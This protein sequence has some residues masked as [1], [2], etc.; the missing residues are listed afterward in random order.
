VRARLLLV[1]GVGEHC[2][3]YGR[4]VQG[5]TV[6]G[7]EVI[8]WDQRGHGLSTG[9]RGH[10]QAWSDYTSD[11]TQVAEWVRG[12]EECQ[13]PCFLYGHSMGG[14]VALAAVLAEAQS[15]NGLI[16]SGMP[17]RPVGV[18]KP[19]LVRLAK[20][21]SGIWPTF[22][23]QLPL[24]PEQMMSDEARQ[25]DME[26]DPLMHTT[27]TVR[28]GMEAMRALERVRHGL[29]QMKVPL[30]VLHGGLDPVNDPSGAEELFQL[31]G[32]PDKTLKVYPN[33]RHEPHNDVQQDD[34]RRD[35]TEW[36]E[37]KMASTPVA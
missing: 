31:A 7:V 17:M 15:W 30:L 1:H 37:M 32:S 19:Y 20:L 18:A 6:Q 4:L 36:L 25:I 23:I 29:P 22:G 27:V 12:G 33:T 26:R 16:V 10:V 13:V 21:L 5:L 14:L 34:V 9:R 11:L 28:W 8:S 24:S 3:R 35:L 2:G